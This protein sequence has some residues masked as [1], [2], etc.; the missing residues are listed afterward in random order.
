MDYYLVNKIQD[1][2]RTPRNFIPDVSAIYG[3]LRI[4][5]QSIMD[6]NDITLVPDRLKS[7]TRILFLD[8]DFDILMFMR[9]LLTGFDAIGLHILVS[10][11][12]FYAFYR[13]FIKLPRAEFGE[14][15]L[16]KTSGVDSKFLI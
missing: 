1:I 13:V 8:M 7:F 6:M 14:G 4:P 11:F 5:P 3:L 2:K 15:H 12:I 16:A 10:A 9:L